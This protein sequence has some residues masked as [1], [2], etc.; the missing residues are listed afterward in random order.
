M[1][2]GETCPTSGI[3]SSDCCSERIALS[4][5]ERFPPCRGVHRAA[6]WTLVQ[7]TK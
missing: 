1:K 7:A 2:T 6:S 4:K 5:G 3:W